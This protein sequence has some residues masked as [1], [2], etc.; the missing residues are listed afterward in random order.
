MKYSKQ[1]FNVLALSQNPLLGQFHDNYPSCSFS[2]T[3]V[4]LMFINNTE[5]Q[6]VECRVEFCFEYSIIKF[7]YNLPKRKKPVAD[8]TW[9][10]L[11][12]PWQI[13]KWITGFDTRIKDGTT[14]YQSAER[15]SLL[16]IWNIPSK[17]PLNGVS[18][19]DFNLFATTQM[20]FVRRTFATPA[21]KKRFFYLILNLFQ[22]L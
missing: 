16:A 3:I 4:I 21:K 22:L 20:G 9:I 15:P 8:L 2:L 19:F 17:S 6:S 7:E 11:F 12:N 10:L 13:V 5:F 1:G 14:P 18:S